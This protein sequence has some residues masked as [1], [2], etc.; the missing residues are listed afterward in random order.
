MRPRKPAYLSRREQE[1][2]DIL[3][4]R[5]SATARQVQQVLSGSPTYSAVRAL[6][7]KLEEKGRVR[8][9]PDGRTYVYSPTTS[10][11]EARKNALRH[12]LR[13]FFDGSPERA[14]TTLLEMESAT[15]DDETMDQLE[16]LIKRAR[17]RR[18]D[19]P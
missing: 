5:G 18:E 9:R 13:T 1:A 3:H 16:S 19:A 14:M 2:M 10:Q 12:L 15:P 7:T 8:H 11:K 17:R 6:L 4:A